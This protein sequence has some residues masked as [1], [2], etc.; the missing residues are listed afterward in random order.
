MTLGIGL[1]IAVMM[2]L[3]VTDLTRRQEVQTRRDHVEQATA[4]GHSTAVTASAWLVSKNFAGLQVLIDGLGIYPDLSHAMVLDTHGQVLA[5]S[6]RQRVGLVLDDLP[7]ATETTVL[8]NSDH[9]IDVVVPV[10]QDKTA[11]GWVRIGL[12]GDGLLAGHRED[13]RNAALF[14]LL[15]IGLTSLVAFLVGRLLTRRLDEIRRVADSVQLGHTAERADES[16]SDEAAV[17]ARQFNTMLDRLDQQQTALQQY[18]NHLEALVVERTSA[19]SIA[20]EAAEAA[21]HAKGQFLSNMGHEIR[22]PMNVI[23]GLTHLLH[24]GATPEQSERLRKIEGA[25][26]HLMSIINDILDLSAIEAGK[27]PLEPEDFSLKSLLDHVRTMI[28]E[29]ARTKGLTVV[30]AADGVPVWLR[31]EATRLQQ[32]L[33]NYASNAVKFTAQ[34]TITLRVRLLEDRGD[35][36]MV[37]FEVQDTGIG[38]PP[39]Q[40]ERLFRAFEQGDASTTRRFGGAGLGLV[41]T[42]H[43]VDLMGGRVGA[44]STVGVG[45]IFWFEVPLARGQGGM[46][47]AGGALDLASVAGQF[48]LLYAVAGLDAE[49]G[50]VALRGKQDRYLELLRRFVAEHVDDMAQV[51]SS[52]AAGDR[53]TAI[54]AAHSLKGVALTLGAELIAETARRIEMALKADLS[55]A[56]TAESLQGEM[57]AIHQAFMAIA[58]VLPAS[59]F[60]PAEVPLPGADVLQAM[61]DALETA[62]AAGDFSAAAQYREHAAVLRVALGEVAEK[63]SIQINQFDFPGALDTLRTYRRS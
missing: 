46:P 59:T 5:H 34:G 16:G 22:T 18:Q 12:N 13:W 27:L 32:S 24:A 7:A 9:L 11:V 54:R 40:C 1:V 62:L 61:L 41:I 53:D 37:R 52:L 14:V 50:L 51:R 19:L 17:L 4:L 21:N 23:L 55:G 33:L 56:L 48:S 60:V 39:E 38:I 31:G 30:V 63:L 20:K 3:F 58:A 35:E 10:M 36:L 25:G 49:R 43:L 57:E 47:V 6:D 42:R 29:G 26:R 2:S 8:Q 28:S 45:S 15:M 44:E